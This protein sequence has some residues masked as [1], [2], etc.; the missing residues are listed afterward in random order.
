MNCS[1][2][3]RAE[4][5]FVLTEAA[6]PQKTTV[7]KPSFSEIEKLVSEREKSRDGFYFMQ[8]NEMNIHVCLKNLEFVPT[9]MY[10][11]F[12]GNNSAQRAINNYR[13]QKENAN[14]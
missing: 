8:I 11:R 2:L 3:S 6:M 10:N 13:Q 1:E 12:N 5:L 4:V 7:K 14:V 9:S